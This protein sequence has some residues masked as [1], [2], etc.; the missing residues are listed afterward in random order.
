MAQKMRKE[1][2]A[3]I[4]QYLEKVAEEINA[5]ATPNDA[6]IK[7]ARDLDIEPGHV[8]LII[9][10]YNNA[11]TNQ[12]RKSSNNL[13][14]KIAAF[15]LA[16]PRRIFNEL[17]PSQIKTAAVLAR[18]TEVSDD[19]KYHPE[20]PRM[21]YS[22]LTKEASAKD[23]TW[24]IP[25]DSERYVKKAWSL[26]RE[27]QQERE[28]RRRQLSAC[29]DK[30]A[31]SYDELLYYFKQVGHPIRYK[32]VK[33]NAEALFGKSAEVLMKYIAQD[34]P[35]LIKEAA[36]RRAMIAVD[37][38]RPPFNLIAK[39][40]EETKKYAQLKAAF[41]TFDKEAAVATERITNYFIPQEIKPPTKFR[42][43]LVKAG[44]LTEEVGRNVFIGLSSGL[45]GNVMGRAIPL[46][47]DKLKTR[48]LLEIMDPSHENKLRAIRSQAIL[49]DILAHDEYLS[50]EAPEKVTG[51]YNQ[52]TQISPRAADQ[53]LLIRALLRRYIAQ[54]QID[55]HDI[56]QLVDI[57]TKLKQRDEPQREYQLPKIPGDLVAQT[58]G[59][60]P[61]G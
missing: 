1:T 26:I 2:E 5:G 53:P 19:Y 14:E 31:S 16:N 41:S 38:N 18:E 24:D 23:K 50:G 34:M 7:V 43:S 17:Y 36:P 37:Y 8:Q 61:K 42:G 28:E 30:V 3:K 15:K 39:C 47:D 29:Y 32:E 49:S 56:S 13:V 48:A 20:L 59:G 40:L 22:V 27:L 54:G 4:L 58:A 33:E 25:R 9:Q 12:Q 46:P 10:A 52:I 57:E 51:L 11:R 60:S 55:P 21:D 6:I 44:G 45:A 35:Q